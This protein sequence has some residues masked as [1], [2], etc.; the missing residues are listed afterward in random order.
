MP[1]KK[2]LK[3]NQLKR[4]KEIEAEVRWSKHREDFDFGGIS[5]EHTLK[6]NI[7]CGG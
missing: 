2:I 1:K 3:E 5:K 4:L 7:G 6:K